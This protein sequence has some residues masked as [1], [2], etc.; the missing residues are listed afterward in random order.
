MEVET[1]TERKKLNRAKKRIAELKG[2]YWHLASYLGVNLFIT[3]V[4]LTQN[5]SSG[6]SFSDAFL[7]FGTFAIWIFWGIGLAAHAIKV[8]SLISIF[9]KDWEEKQIQKFIQEEQERAEKF[10]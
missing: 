10:R 9:G 1:R 2:F 5:M 6:E 8:F 7:D 3:I 4:K